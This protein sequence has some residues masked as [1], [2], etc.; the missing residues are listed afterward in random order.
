[1]DPRSY[2]FRYPVSNDL[3]PLIPFGETISIEHFADVMEEL[4]VVLDGAT[5]MFFEHIQLKREMEEEFEDGHTLY[6]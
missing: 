1:L 6:Y 2:S 5:A 3:Q 4:D